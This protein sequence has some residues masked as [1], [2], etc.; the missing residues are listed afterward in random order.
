MMC[1]S[2]STT[3]IFEV[4]G[5]IPSIDHRAVSALSRLRDRNVNSPCCLRLR[6]ILAGPEYE[7][8]GVAQQPEPIADLPLQ[9][10]TIGEVEQPD[11]VHEQHHRRRLRA[12]LRA[13]AEAQAPPLVA[14]WRMLVEGLPED[15]VQLVGGH[16]DSSLPD[17]LQRHRQDAADALLR[18]R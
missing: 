9:V 3:R 4:I 17:D 14:G 11:I 2:S 10:A 16:L 18:L 13:V 15:L 1:A 7:L 12:R 6:P 8:D 5:D